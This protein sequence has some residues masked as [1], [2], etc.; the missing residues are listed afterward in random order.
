VSVGIKAARV[1]TGTIKDAIKGAD[2]ALYISKRSN[3]NIVTTVL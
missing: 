3:K 1:G 2:E